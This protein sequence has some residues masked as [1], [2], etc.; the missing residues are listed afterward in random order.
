LDV[1]LALAFTGIAYLV[2][3]LVAWATRGLVAD[4]VSFSAAFDPNFPPATRIV[5]IVFVDAGVAI[6]LV[7]ILW[8]V[9]S[10]FLIIYA[11]RQKFSISWAWMSGLCQA[12]VAALGGV[13]VA[14]AVHLPYQPVAARSVPAATIISWEKLSGIS[15]PILAVLAI[16]IWV[17]FLV[18]LLVERARVNR[19]GPSLRDGLRTNIY[20]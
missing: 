20:R 9:V 5:R 8:L 7:G 16:L 1:G 12:T 10:M 17:T 2:W 15:L 19:R 18:L 4:M 3:V 13:L 14:W 11:S 6:D